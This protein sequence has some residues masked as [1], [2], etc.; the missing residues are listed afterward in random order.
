MIVDKKWG[1][2]L[3]LEQGIRLGTVFDVYSSNIQ[4]QSWKMHLT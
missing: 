3:H 2:D 4:T 1:V